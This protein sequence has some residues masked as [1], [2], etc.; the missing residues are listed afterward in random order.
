LRSAKRQ[1]KVDSIF[2]E[3]PFCIRANWTRTQVAFNAETLMMPKDK[4]VQVILL[5]E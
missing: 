1:K 5:E 4:D 2:F 3:R